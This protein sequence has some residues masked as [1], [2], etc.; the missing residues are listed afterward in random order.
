[1]G[2]IIGS[3]AKPKRCNLSKLSQLGTPAA[4]EY[5]LVSSDNSMN[6]AGQ[7]N[8]DCY[9][10][11]VGNVAATEL[12]LHTIA[13]DAPTQGS[14]NS[15][16]S[17]AVYDETK[18][19]G[20][21]VLTPTLID[22]LLVNTTT[23]SK[24]ATYQ[25]YYV[26]VIAGDNIQVLANFTSNTMRTGYTTVTPAQYKAID[27]Y[28]TFSVAQAS[29]IAT[30]FV[31]PH[32][33][34]LCV[35]FLTSALVSLEIMGVND[36]LGGK[37]YDLTQKVSGIEDNVDVLNDK[38]GGDVLWDGNVKNNGTQVTI[39][40]LANPSKEDVYL[41]ITNHMGDI[42]NARVYY[43]DETYTQVNINSQEDSIIQVFAEDATHGK[44]TR[45]FIFVGQSRTADGYLKVVNITAMS[46][47]VLVLDNKMAVVETKI[48]IIEGSDYGSANIGLLYNSGN[49]NPLSFD[50]ALGQ[51]TIAGSTRIFANS[52]FMLPLANQNPTTL[53][54]TEDFEGGAIAFGGA[55]VYDATATERNYKIIPNTYSV[56]NRNFF[57]IATFTLY[58][59]KIFV[60]SPSSFLIDGVKEQKST[61]NTIKPNY[62]VIELPNSVE[63]WSDFIIIE[64]NG[65]KEM[66]FFKPSSEEDH[67]STNGKIH[68]VRMSDW[69]YI[70]SIS[71]DF[72]HC[73]TCDYDA[74]RDILLIGNL[75]GNTEY[76]A[77]LYIFY[78][79]SSW[80]NLSAIHFEDTPTPTIVDLSAFGMRN[81]SACFGEAN[82]GT[83]NIVYVQDSVTTHKM[84]KVLLGMGTNNLAGG[85]ADGVH[86]QANEYNGT[87][88]VLE[89][90]S[91]YNTLYTN[92]NEVIQG[93]SYF[94]GK[95]L[96]SNGHGNIRGFIWCKNGTAWEREEIFLQQFNA[97]GTIRYVTSEGF[98]RDGDI[99][100]QGAIPVTNETGTT[101]DTDRP[102]A[103]ITYEV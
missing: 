44:V 94:H 12:P 102:F 69:T 43:E 70:G 71:H 96:T 8:F 83:R 18:F 54:L 79:V 78:N 15:V 11:G 47:D 29:G 91:I 28:V 60:N 45:V 57:V 13:D 73:N 35:S 48:A 50:S 89:A 64:I 98:T 9:I 53:S 81:I 17:G 85:T 95:I 4:G 5:I 87:Y 51:V 49:A 2:Q 34:F 62:K 82:G 30:T 20:T 38:I 72:G 24:S 3:A 14:K 93:I 19:V 31:A 61:L 100:Y 39:Y 56:F 33:G 101:K 21:S 16:T 1:M 41:S 6:E 32:D 90:P 10:V 23:I 58:Q 103:I 75:P 76:S 42:L 99:I 22:G 86:T 92:N 40:D 88:Q 59:S 46:K 68:R 36:H 65:T 80:A 55:L 74:E 37:V 25:L 7:G 84:A 27:N 66:W 63:W 77:A 52:K 67:V 97:D 26:P